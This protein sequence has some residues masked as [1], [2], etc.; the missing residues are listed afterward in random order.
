MMKIVSLRH[1][2]AYLHG[3]QISG[4]CYRAGDL[5]ELADADALAMLL[6]E[7]SGAG[8]QGDPVFALQW[9]A[10]DPLDYEVPLAAVTGRPSYPG[11]TRISPHDRWGPPVLGTGFAPSSHFLVPEFVTADLAD[12]PLPVNT[13]LVAHTADGEVVPLYSYLPEQRA[14]LRLFGARWRHLIAALPEIAPDQEYVQIARDASAGPRLVG[15]FLGE[16]HDAIADPPHEFRVATKG[17]GVRYMVQDLVRRVPYAVW[18]GVTCTV[19]HGERDWLRLRLCRPDMQNIHTL[20][21]QCME[22]GSYE[23][24]APAVEVDVRETDVR[25]RLDDPVA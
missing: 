13:M 14:W 4:F 12:L 22:R 19:V 18:R 7:A 25:Y 15:R 5:G 21:A 24:W 20:G 2:S 3:R 23:A 6:G 8:A 11:L 16:E 9:R 17:K 10:V 1:V